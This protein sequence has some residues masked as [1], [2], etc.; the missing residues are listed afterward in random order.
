M[1]RHPARHPQG[2]LG[3]G[4][5][6]SLGLINSSRGDCNTAGDCWE[7]KDGR[8]KGRGGGPDRNEWGRC[9]EEGRRGVMRKRLERDGGARDEDG[10]ER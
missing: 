10:G 4:Q 7:K 8:K 3:R 2:L 6:I 1:G 9:A 5:P